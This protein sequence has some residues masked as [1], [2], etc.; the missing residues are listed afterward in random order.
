MS[1]ITAFQGFYEVGRPQPGQIIF[2]SSAAGAMGQI[3]GQL[4]NAEGL[5]V[6]GSVGSND[7]VD[8]IVKD[9]GFDAGFNYKTGSPR[10]ALARL[11]PQGIDLYF[12]NVGGNHLDAALDF[13]KM[14]GRVIDCDMMPESNTPVE[15]QL[16]V[17]NIYRLVS[18]RIIYQ[19]FVVDMSTEKCCGIPRG[20]TAQVR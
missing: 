16:G 9:L 19:G 3:V 4:A 17:R 5:T 20:S 14:Y 15:G 10:G 6:I 2:T 12:D 18:K 7:K 8:F 13:F 1:G 11:A